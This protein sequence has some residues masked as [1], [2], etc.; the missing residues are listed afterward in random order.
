MNLNLDLNFNNDLATGI[1]DGIALG[2]NN[3]LL[4][5][6]RKQSALVQFLSKISM[7]LKE[8]RAE[9]KRKSIMDRP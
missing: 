6:K 1:S 4:P 5:I 8:H 3:S 7:H 9:I 2:K